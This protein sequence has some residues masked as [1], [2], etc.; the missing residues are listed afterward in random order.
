MG[1]LEKLL[2]EFARHADRA[3]F[4]LRFVTL[5]DRGH[6][7]DEIEALGWPVLA[8]GMPTGLRPR[9]VLELARLFRRER[10]DVVHTHSEGPLLYGAPAARL[11]GVGR[12]DPHPA[13]RAR[14]RQQLAAGEAGR[15]PASR[16]GSTA[17]SA[18]P[19]TARGTCVA[20]GVPA[21]RV[22]TVRNGI[23][24]ARF[25][26]TGPRPGGPAVIV[27]RLV[28]EKDHATLLR[29]WARVVA[30]EPDFR[31]EI[32]GDGP[33]LAALQAA[34]R[35][36]RP[37]RPRPLPRPGRR[38][39][40]AAR[41][42]GDAR[43]LVADGGDLLDAAGGDGARASRSSPR[44]S[45]ATPRS[46]STARPGCSSR[47]V[48]PRTWPP[49][50]SRSA[51]TPSRAAGWAS[52]AATGPSGI[53]TSG[54]PSRVTKTLYMDRR[55]ARASGPRR[56]RRDVE[57]GGRRRRL[58]VPGEL[59]GANPDAQPPDPAGAAAPGHVRRHPQPRPRRGP[60]GAGI[61]GRPR[62][63][64][65]RG[66]AHRPAPSR[67]SASTPGWRRTWRPRCPTRS[68]RTRAPP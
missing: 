56:G 68:P 57:R 47:P 66:R 20:E 55:P 48:R 41:P 21:D 7:A 17:S 11:A 27:A 36:A 49:P 52:P 22:V 30:E 16:A 33:C 58:A 67:A 50:S 64:G 60:R 28:P 15:R 65:G 1:G 38:R 35:R 10:V 29:A 39:R 45:A 2:V 54:G 8:L 42:G 32:A 12:V 44:G 3:R 43:P 18:S 31:L 46:S 5:G 9:A 63:R 62:G 13:P 23:D 34:G 51:A 26:Y 53:S 40:R 24:L 25:A 4:D 6:L 59:G 37:G 14:P 61:P 19:T